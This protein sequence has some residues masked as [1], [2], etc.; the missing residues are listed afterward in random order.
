M[1]KSGDIY[2]DLIFQ[3]AKQNDDPVG[4]DIVYNSIEEE[5]KRSPDPWS[6]QVD[7]DDRARDQH[8]ADGD[9]A[10]R[11]GDNYQEEAFWQS[12]GYVPG[13]WENMDVCEVISKKMEALF[14]TI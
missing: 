13:E 14:I 7:R 5:E 12:A 6:D 4:G 10:N 9:L 3:L 11:N 1:S 2:D 8:T